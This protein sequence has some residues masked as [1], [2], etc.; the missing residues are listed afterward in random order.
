MLYIGRRNH[1]FN[2]RKANK[3]AQDSFSSPSAP[4]LHRCCTRMI[5]VCTAKGEL[6]T[7]AQFGRVVVGRGTRCKMRRRGKTRQ[8]N[9][10]M[11]NGNLAE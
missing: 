11:L 1:T 9:I 10:S 6:V 2:H 4:F 3:M 7:S 8:R 5:T